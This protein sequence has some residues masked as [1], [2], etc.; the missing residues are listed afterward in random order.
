MWKCKNMSLF[1]TGTARKAPINHTAIGSPTVADF[2]GWRSPYLLSS[3]WC[4]FRFSWIECL[5]IWKRFFSLG[6][7]S[8]SWF[9]MCL[10]CRL[11]QWVP[12]IMPPPE[13][14]PTTQKWRNWAGPGLHLTAE[15][16]V[17]QAKGAPD[18]KRSPNFS[19]VFGFRLDREFFLNFGM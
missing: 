1:Y 2:C 14:A 3:Y 10:C 6:S 4:K 5:E 17:V 15:W 9:W 16:R 19:D 18:A 12:I 8:W 13:Q 11:Y 7:F